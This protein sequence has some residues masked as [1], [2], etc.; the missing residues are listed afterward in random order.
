MIN[1]FSDMIRGNR[2]FVV[3]L[4]LLVCSCS[5][6][7]AA[8]KPGETFEPE[9]AFEKANGLLEKKDYEEARTAF[10][11]IKNRDTSRKFA[12]LA[13]LKIAD[14][15]VK[16]GES[17]L[18]IAEFRKFLE[19]YP[20]H[21]YAVYAQY[22]IAS[23]YFDQ[24]EGPERGYSGAAKA[25]EEFEKLKK[26]YPRNPYREVIDIKIQKCRNV[27]AGYEFLVGEFYYKKGSFNAAINRFRDI[28]KTYPDYQREAEVFFYIGMSY[29]NLGQKDK[30]SEYLK[31]LVEKYPNNKFTADAK[32]ELVKF[33]P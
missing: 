33:K 24:I 25:L 3:L 1:M 32:K 11:E 2:L 22:Q 31:R 15:Y 8:V 21:K 28:L 29:K 9:K 23:A 19:A 6:K 12:P 7:L 17:E 26:M 20:D 10:L 5:S 27:I 30:A 13:Q 16:E 14:S 18:A 4:F